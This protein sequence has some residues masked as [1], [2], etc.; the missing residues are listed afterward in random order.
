MQWQMTPYV[1]I[2]VISMVLSGILAAYGW[3]YRST[4]G[5]IPFSIMTLAVSLWAFGYMVEKITALFWLQKLSAYVQVI[6]YASVPFLWLIFALHYTHREAW[7]TPRRIGLLMITPALVTLCAWTSEIHRWFFS[8]FQTVHIGATVQ[9]VVIFGPAFWVHTILAYG[10]LAAGTVLLLQGVFRSHDLYR[11]QMVLLIIGAVFPWAVNI[12]SILNLIPLPNLDLTTFAF[13]ITGLAI[14]GSLFRYRLFDIV[15]VAYEAIVRS[16]DDMV[17]VLDMQNRVADLNPAAKAFFTRRNGAYQDGA[18]IGKPAEQVLDRWSEIAEKYPGAIASPIEIGL[19]DGSEQRWFDLH[20][21]HLRRRH[22]QPAGQ[23]FVLHDITAS[24]LAQKAL[25]EAHDQITMLYQVETE[26]NKKLDLQYVL[27]M[28]QDAAVWISKAEAA[29]IGLSDGEGI[30]IAQVHGSYPPEMINTRLRREAGIAGRVMRRQRPELIPDVSID[31]DYDAI[32]PETR[33]QI[34]LPL[35]SQEH[36]IGILNL[37]TTNPE[38]FEPVIFEILKLLAARIA[39]AIDNARMYEER[40][41]LVKDLDAYAHSVAHDLKNP[42]GVILAYIEMI[43][44]EYSPS[45]PETVQEY[46]KVIDRN[47]RKT[48]D[49]INALLLIA[50]VR[51]GK[52]VVMDH[53]NM[54]AIVSEVLS[55]LSNDISVSQAR[56]SVPDR[57]PD[58][59]GYGPWIEEVWVNYISNAIKYGGAPPQI[60]LGATEQPGGWVRFWIKDNGGGISQEDQA[61]L[62]TQFTRLDESKTDG[63]GLGLSIVQR[64]VE[65]LG[66]QVGIESAVGQGSTFFFTL[67]AGNV[68]K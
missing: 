28:A 62:F 17:V 38:R 8:D 57:W 13:T 51:E 48:I 2:I 65:K 55:R 64:I 6:G 26:L 18:V 50:N 49:I 36:F 12:V 43:G 66:G 44:L 40:E 60:E 25:Q 35:I 3:R 5:A 4:P 27:M 59:L 45:L 34:T 22:E 11:G 21:S 16:M 41:R 56:I 24:K 32:I 7:L 14:A 46:H 68:V 15:P 39:A 29:F 1:L 23:L 42:I 10:A 52:E 37:E 58:V 67:P 9:L 53:P 63:H 61:R 20:A 47:S 30:R 33:A 54:A 31:P 19:G